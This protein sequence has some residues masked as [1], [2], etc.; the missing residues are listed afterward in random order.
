MV[1]RLIVVFLLA[2]CLSVLFLVFRGRENNTTKS[3]L[4]ATVLC[5]LD[6]LVLFITF[7][8]PWTLFP[9]SL[10]DWSWGPA[11]NE[12]GYE[13]SLMNSIYLTKNKYV[14]PDG[15]SAE[16]I[17]I[18][19]MSDLENEGQRKPDVILILNETFSELGYYCDLLPEED[20]V[21]QLYETE[22]IIH[23]Y[24]TVSLVGGGTNNSEYE[25]LTSN[26]MAGITI[27][28]PFLVFDMNN[29]NSVVSHLEKF[30]YHTVGMHCGE[31][32]NYGRN[33]AYPA[34]G[35]DDIYLG[36]DS[37]Q[38]YNVY[39]NRP[40]LDKDNYIDLIQAYEGCGEEPRFMYLL[41]YQ[42]HG[43]Y[44]QNP[45]EEDLISIK[46][47][48]GTYIDDV[49]EYLSSMKLSVEAFRELTEYFSNV[50]RDTIILM[51]G[52]HMP[53]FI[54]QLEPKHGIE[55]LQCDISQKTVPY[56]VWANFDIGDSAFTNHSSMVDLIPMLLKTAGIPLSPYYQ[57]ILDLN[58]VLPIRTQEGLVADEKGVIYYSN[59]QLPSY[60][61]IQNY[62][63][64]EYNNLLHGDDYRNELFEI[65]AQ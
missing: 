64:M 12:Y 38:E 37:F 18:P 32:R 10:F 53:S 13:I 59:D 44:E 55:G 54:S 65:A 11:V 17:Q 52:D 46:E 30:G 1:L 41:T 47:D 4:V 45:P 6:A 7:F 23:G 63:Y 22:R 3:R 60:E 28:A 16:K 8:S 26:S 19:E 58:R 48:F 31:K 9:T 21:N 15:Y 49:N 20:P 27:S 29:A 51:V 50:D 43:G 40:W 25:L 2:I 33:T 61:L 14:I 24:S 57:Y 36:K 39:G 62:Y 35:F 34:V 5:F 56:I 42:N